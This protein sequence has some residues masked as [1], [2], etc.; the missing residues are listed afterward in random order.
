MILILL[1]LISALLLWPWARGRKARQRI[2][3]MKACFRRDYDADRRR[4]QFWH[5]ALRRQGH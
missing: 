5:D 1:I 2:Q 4:C 3:R